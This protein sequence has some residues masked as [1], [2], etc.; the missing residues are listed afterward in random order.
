MRE[1]HAVGGRS[2]EWCGKSLEGYRADATVCSNTCYEARRSRRRTE[3]KK[4]LRSPDC[5]V[6]GNV[7]PD[8]RRADA[9]TCSIPCNDKRK[10]LR[11]RAKFR[12][13]KGSECLE[14]GNAIPLSV[15]ANVLYC[16]DKCRLAR[17]QRYDSQW[18]ADNRDKVRAYVRKWA[19]ENPDV[20][21]AHRH[22]RRALM[23][24][25]YVEDVVA[26][27]IFKRDEW[28]CGICGEDIDSGLEW[29]DPMSVTLDHIVPLAAGGKHERANCQAA[30]YSCN[31]R[32]GARI[33]SE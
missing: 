3:M 17:K 30:H 18:A 12:Q 28:V 22:K 2:C 1:L 33:A 27:E 14:C 19:K 29:P 20:M 10:S 7:I 15:S 21:S 4:S 24:E 31:S 13:V 25:A 26:S 16:S 6:C 32:K 8:T 23:R 5:V 9:E 11:R